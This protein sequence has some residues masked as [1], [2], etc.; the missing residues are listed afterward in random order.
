[1]LLL[2]AGLACSATTVTE[3]AGGDGDTLLSPGAAT[4]DATSPS[5][6]SAP[7]DPDG[8]Y[9]T[10]CDYVLGN[11]T[12]GPSGYRFLG[13]AKIH[14]TGNIGIVVN[15]EAHWDQLGQAPIRESKTVEI[16][17]GKT[18]SVQFT[19]LATGNELDLHQSAGFDDA[20]GVKVKIVDTFG[21]IH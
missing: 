11:F 7:K 20:C 13:G 19:Y 2:A 16:G 14:N 3:T 12:Y 18:K 4:G 1:M 10:E 6:P 15:V 5:E 9:S 21:E 17:Y 8:R